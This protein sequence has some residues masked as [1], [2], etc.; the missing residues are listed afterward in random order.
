[1]YLKTKDQCEVVSRPPKTFEPV[2]NIS[3]EER[4]LKRDRL[5]SSSTRTIDVDLDDDKDK[6]EDEIHGHN[7]KKRKR[8]KFI[9]KVMEYAQRFHKPFKNLKWRR[10]L[11]RIDDIAAMIVAACVDKNEVR[12]NGEGYVIGNEQFANE[13]LNVLNCISDRLELKI[14]VDLRSIEFPDAI[15][16]VEDDEENDVISEKMAYT[17]MGEATG[18]GYERI[19]RQCNLINSFTFSIYSE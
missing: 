9:D 18:R 12:R 14:G 13:V 7:V 3:R 1:M 4:V 19:R 15:E 6:D 8:F 10:R 5:F 2:E 16:L 17:I 11:E